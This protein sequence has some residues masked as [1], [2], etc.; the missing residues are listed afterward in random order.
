MS[1]LKLVEP[2]CVEGLS[3]F[4]V[5]EMSKSSCLLRQHSELLSHHDAYALDT[6]LKPMSS[7]FH[8]DSEWL[9]VRI[10]P[11]VG[12]SSTLRKLG[13]SRLKILM[14]KIISSVSNSGC[15]FILLHA[16]GLY[17]SKIVRLLHEVHPITGG[18]ISTWT[19][20]RVSR[21]II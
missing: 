9:F 2:A 1:M 18:V 11:T 7:Y 20:M 17:R 19:T 13:E 3:N 14:V 16:L 5:L 15:C 12:Y 6:H 4:M 10:F 8:L 21:R